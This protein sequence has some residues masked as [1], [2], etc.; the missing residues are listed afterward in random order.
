[1]DEFAVNRLPGEKPQEV[2]MIRTYLT[3]FFKAAIK[4]DDTAEERSFTGGY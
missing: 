3:S 2:V 4:S 1:M